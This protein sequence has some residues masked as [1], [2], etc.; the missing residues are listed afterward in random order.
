MKIFSMIIGLGIGLTAFAQRPLYFQADVNGVKIIPQ[1]FEY[2][3]IDA[4]KIRIGDI[5]IDASS[6]NFQL[7]PTEDSYALKFKWPA[8][9]IDEGE[10]LVLNNN[11][12]ALWTHPI[13]KDQIKIS[14][15]PVKVANLRS[16]LAEFTSEPIEPELLKAFKLIPFMN[17]CVFHRETNTKIYLCSKELFVSSS[18]KTPVIK[19]RLGAKRQAQITINGKNVGHQGIIFLNNRSEN[20]FF[21]A[22]AESGAYLEID[23]RMNNVDF[24]DVVNSQDDKFIIV[25]AA[26]AEPV[27]KVQ[28]LGDELW[29]ARVPKDRPILYL[30]GAG[31]IPMRQEFL[32]SGKVPNENLR[33][34]VEDESPLETFSD[35]ITLNGTYP[36]HA[37]IETTNKVDQLQVFSGNKFTWNLNALPSG[38][39]T[40]RYLKVESGGQKYFARYDI[41]RNFSLF[42]TG[43]L[44]YDTP[45]GIA[46]GYLQGQWW[47]D[48]FLSGSALELQADVHLTKKE[49]FPEFDI[50]RLLYLYKVSE[51]EFMEDDTWGLG[52]PMTM[53]SGRGFSFSS[54][55]VKLWGMKRAPEKLPAS[56]KWYNP[57]LT[58]LMSS[59]GGDVKLS[60]CYELGVNFYTPMRQKDYLIYGLRIL[61]LTFDPS[62]EEQKMQ[63]GLTVGY[64]TRL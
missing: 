28:I 49:G 3:L 5:L 27:S 13:K 16:E 10:L 19:N 57:Y 2:A 59:A 53:F 33:L 46:Y 63:F 56:I 7:V 64:S 47:L 31:G 26:G 34:Y 6:L 54:F 35:A 62:F 11:G 50:Y 43:G 24:K 55:G 45:S 36:A 22:S 52:I 1:K 48:G 20:I 37:K 18:Q 9:L 30:K 17:F 23:T 12:K 29:Q 40:R 61:N 8:G 42:L 58:Y 41:E 14:A 38:K 15:N 21:K 39:L 60:S 4:E 32:I 44:N 25:T 51:G